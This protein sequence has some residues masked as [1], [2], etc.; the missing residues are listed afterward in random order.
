MGGLELSSLA[1]RRPSL[2]SGRGPSLPSVFRFLLSLTRFFCCAGLARSLPSVGIHLALRALVRKY[3]A[4]QALLSLFQAL[5]GT[6]VPFSARSLPS[7]RSFASFRDVDLV[8]KA[9]ASLCQTFLFPTHSQRAFA[10]LWQAARG[11]PVGFPPSGRT[12]VPSH[13]QRGLD[14]SFAIDN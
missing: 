12:R 14:A 2:S 13:G 10:S 8:P 7:D 11:C 4:G 1:G 6:F 5:S 9:L 3:L